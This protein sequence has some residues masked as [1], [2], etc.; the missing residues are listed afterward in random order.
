MFTAAKALNKLSIY[1]HTDLKVS[2]GVSETFK[3][4]YSSA[5]I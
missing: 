2:S 4:K 5:H 1:Q 3:V